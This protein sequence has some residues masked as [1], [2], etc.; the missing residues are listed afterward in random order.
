MKLETRNLKLGKT[1]A[2]VAAGLVLAAFATGCPKRAAPADACADAC[3]GHEAKTAAPGTAAPS[4]V[5][6]NHGH[7]AAAPVKDAHGHAAEKG[8]EKK[9]EG[10]G[11][12][13]EVVLAPAAIAANKVMVEPVA[14]REL[15]TRFTLPGRVA[16]D[17]EKT[18]HIGTPV[19]GRV[20]KILVQPGDAVKMGDALLVIESTAAGEAQANYLQKRMS[21]KTAEGALALSAAA[22]ERGG[23]LKES[24]A[25]SNA[26]IAKRDTEKAAAQN[27]LQAAQAEQMAA[28]NS[29]RLLGFDDAALKALA[30]TGAVSTAYTVRAPIDGVVVE[31]EVTPGEVVGPERE[32][33]ARLADTKALWV[34]ADAPENRLAEAAAGAMAEV[35]VDALAG[36]LFAGKV[37]YVAPALNEVTRTAQV[38]VV[39][40]DA[41]SAGVLRAG[42]F[43]RVAVSV[44]VKGGTVLAVPE[45]AVLN[46]EGG[47]A[48]FVAVEGEPGAFQ[49]RAIVPGAVAGGWIPVLSGLK[50]GE[51]VVTG[52]AFILK[53][54]LAKGIMEGKTCTGH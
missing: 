25:L 21:V 47:P 34:L 22:A 9:A 17:T 13:D 40:D 1:A 39:L 29:L 49:K 18:A 6:D 35:T 28:E 24:G 15:S 27:A 48:V 2:L 42:M 52:G 5:K 3:G 7:E 8:G 11:C 38:R 10:D 33:L 30:E 19:A 37:T 51:K 4:P 12:E 50:A 32:A 31:R 43:A 41:E 26:E 36:K 45:G 23:K 54:E 14:M 20:A 53:A 46:V 16:F 44:P